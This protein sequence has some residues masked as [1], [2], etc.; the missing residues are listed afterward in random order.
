MAV[1]VRPAQ[2]SDVRG[3]AA[4]LARAF[5]DDPVMAWLLPDDR[6][7]EKALSRM[8]AAITRR[9]FLPR[10]ASEVCWRDAAWVLR[11]CGTRRDGGRPLGSKNLR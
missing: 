10:E 9:H 7:R 8:F 11:R 3:M 1:D 4:V 5:Y 2:R 6:S